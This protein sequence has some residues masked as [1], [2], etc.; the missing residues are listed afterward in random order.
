M[1]KKYYL[2]GPM[3]G[4]DDNNIPAFREAAETLRAAGHEIVSP[5]EMDEAAKD[6]TVS[7]DS[8]PEKYWRFLAR[9]IETIGVDCDGIVFLPDWFHSRGAKLE[10]MAGLMA[11]LD[12]FYYL[13]G[14]IYA[15]SPMMIR[16]I[17]GVRTD[18]NY[19]KAA[20]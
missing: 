4:I 13:S 10:A 15:V 17:L 11:Q 19:Q 3:S 20:A 1:S 14:E 8:N 12:F 16:S 18:V 9:D 2:A 6:P 5:V 7:F